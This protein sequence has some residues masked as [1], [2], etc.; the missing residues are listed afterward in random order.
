MS[1]AALEEGVAQSAAAADDDDADVQSRIDGFRDSRQTRELRAAVGVFVV[2][3]LAS[4]VGLYFGNLSKH[5]GL[6]PIYWPVG[7][8]FSLLGNGIAYTITE[9]LDFERGFGEISLAQL[10]DPQG[11]IWLPALLAL[12]FNLAQ[13]MPTMYSKYGPVYITNYLFVGLYCFASLVVAL[14]KG[15]INIFSPAVT[16]TPVWR[17]RATICEWLAAMYGIGM[18][19]Y[20][21]I[22]LDLWYRGQWEGALLGADASCLLMVLVHSALAAR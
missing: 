7:F 5:I 15:E 6:P 20:V 18:W 16:A 9:A 17:R 22:Y 13:T 14:S 4:A 2:G 19:I 1:A 12:W 8:G 11:R 10:R 21:Y 3:M